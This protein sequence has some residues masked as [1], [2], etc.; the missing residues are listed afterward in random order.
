MDFPKSEFWDFT[1]QIYGKDGVSPAVI[2]LQDKRGL[3]VD[4]LLFCCFL[5]V[6]GRGALGAAEAAKAKALADP[7][8]AQVV[9]AIR[10]VRRKLKEGFPG[11]PAGLPET[12]RKEIFG[13]ELAAERI[14]QMMLES[15]VPRAPD[16]ARASEQ[17]V[18]DGAAS[19]KSYLD[20][21]GIKAGAED[22]THLA[23]LLG[24]AMGDGE[25]AKGAL[26]AVYA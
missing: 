17:R 6:T 16:A 5:A 14:E 4:I 8:Q 13:Q 3:D 20:A 22:M 10:L 23:T 11:T 25:G 18:R 12:L 19:L 2:A 7:W 24:A 26:A 21:C 1:L 9:N 15:A